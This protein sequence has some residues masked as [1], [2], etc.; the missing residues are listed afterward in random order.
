M[1]STFNQANEDTPPSPEFFST[2]NNVSTISVDEI[3]PPSVKHLGPISRNYSVPIT[4]APQAEDG[5]TGSQ[6]FE[7]TSMGLTRTVSYEERSLKEELKQQ[8]DV[9]RKR[10]DTLQKEV[11]TKND[12]INTKEMELQRALGENREIKA[13]YEDLSNNQRELISELNGVKNRLDTVETE[14]DRLNSE[15]GF[16]SNDPKTSGEKGG[17]RSDDELLAETL[18]PMPLLKRE[19][20][21]AEEA[22]DTTINVMQKQMNKLMDEKKNI[23]SG[24]EKVEEARRTQGAQLKELEHQKMI[25]FDQITHLREQLAH[26]QHKNLALQN[27][28]KEQHT[29]TPSGN[30]ASKVVT[31]IEAK[32]VEYPPD[33]TI[34]QNLLRAQIEFYFSNYNLKRDKP[35]LEKMV[36]NDKHKGFLS[37]EEI[38]KLPK[39]RQLAPD[40][41]T[42]M[43]ALKRSEYLRIEETPSTCRVGRP[44]FTEPERQEFPFRRTVFVYG[45]P[46]SADQPYVQGI[47]DSFGT[48]KKIKFDAGPDTLDRHIGRRLLNKP[49]VK[50]IYSTCSLHY[51]LQFTSKHP[52]QYTIFKC[53]WCVR[54]FH[55]IQ[56]FYHDE[57]YRT[58][59]CLQC[60][61]KRA[62]SQLGEFN[63]HRSRGIP[64]LSSELL[65]DDAKRYGLTDYR[66]ALVVFESQ[67]QAS[68]CVYVRSRLGFEG[69]FATHFH[70]YS[71]LKKE[72]VSTYEPAFRL[73]PKP[74]E[75]PNQSRFGSPMPRRPELK[76][77][78]SYSVQNSAREIR[79]PGGN[80]MRPPGFGNRATSQGSFSKQGANFQT[81]YE[82][83][84]QKRQQHLRNQRGPSKMDS[85]QKGLD[86]KA[87]AWHRDPSRGNGGGMPQTLK[88]RRYISGPQTNQ[89]KKMAIKHVNRGPQI[90]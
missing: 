6:G 16:E 5:R 37:I 88:M 26:E 81:L 19:K 87:S 79:R 61:A 53:S 48:I 45:L 2:G 89:E 34:I 31:S 70:H 68:K 74:S 32:D 38:E 17:S 4:T 30:A 86:P 55:S 41:P 82:Q 42:I 67:R 56:G 76:S 21:A 59:V 72:Q 20:S 3:A 57:N 58:L 33:E 63:D 65:G 43:Q 7:I 35:L 15:L 11:N 44:N 90:G 78:K 84:E 29:G 77:W 8:K 66:T 54:Q 47:C 1:K 36:V 69:C 13:S 23:Y 9:A 40:R 24:K 60:A 62:E 50:K 14:R 22:M 71:K 75:E 52:Q 64:T 51:E 80:K 39:V 18:P 12:T 27:L 49:R 85:P 28:L 73:V 83:H 10:I 25:Q 46:A